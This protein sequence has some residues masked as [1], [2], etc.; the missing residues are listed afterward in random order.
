MN[1]RSPL[2]KARGLGAAGHGPRDWWRQRVTAVAL[3]PLSLWFAASLASLP[4][5]SYATV[6]AWIAAPW[7]NILL[8]AF[9]LATAYHTVLG[10]QVIIEDYVHT[11]WLKLGSLLVVKLL[12]AFLALASTHATLRIALL[13]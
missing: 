9:I 5:A 13:N 4:G 10:L 11:D 8:I 3:L 2:G 12:I 6:I 1:Y 7:N